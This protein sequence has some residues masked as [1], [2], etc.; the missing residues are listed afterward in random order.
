MNTSQITQ[1]KEFD[2]QR[3]KWL[4]LS[5]FVVIAVLGT[6]FDWNQ[7]QYYKLE[8]T[9]ASLGIA[10]AVF[11]WYWTMRVIRYLIDYKIKEHELL[12]EVV[13][14]IRSIKQEIVNQKD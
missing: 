1:L 8:W 12:N 7:I 2:K 13:S 6:V 9:L 10:L 4:A 14:D 11:W 5:T 3:K